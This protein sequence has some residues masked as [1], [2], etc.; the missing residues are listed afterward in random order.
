[1]VEDGKIAAL[2]PALARDG[3]AGDV[4]IV[5]CGGACLAPGLVDMRVQLAR[6]RRRAQGDDGDG[7]PA[8]PPRAAS[9]PWWRCPTPSPSIDELALVEFV[10]RRAR[11]IGLANIRTYAAATKGLKGTELT[12]MGLLAAAGAVAFTDGDHAPSPTRW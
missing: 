1:M 6:A 3:L 11:D 2:G 8:P 5:D 4:E 10:A 7:R 9:P 12:E